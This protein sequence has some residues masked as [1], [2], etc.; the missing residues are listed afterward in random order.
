M[1]LGILKLPES[2]TISSDSRFIVYKPIGDMYV[3]DKVVFSNLLFG[4]TNTTFY[5]TISTNT[6][7]TTYLTTTLDNLSSDVNTQ[8]NLLSAYILNLVKTMFANLL[9]DSQPV[10]FVKYTV[11][12]INPGNYTPNTTWSLLSGGYFIGGVGSNTDK[13]S[14]SITFNAGVDSN[15]FNLGEVSH[16]LTVGELP[17][18]T[19]TATQTQETNATVAGLYTESANSPTATGIAASTSTS[20]G[21][22]LTHNNI[23]PFYGL[24]AWERIA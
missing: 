21:G 13:N 24:Y 1:Q 17:A 4:P 5:H 7:N 15:N 11:D 22:G 19:H 16:T 23:P 12:N 3:T 10:G 9:V 6:S 20:T 18:H 8:T 14:D 2:F